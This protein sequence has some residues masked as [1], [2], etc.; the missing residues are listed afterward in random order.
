[1]SALELVVV[2]PGDRDE[3]EMLA[4]AFHAEDGHP[5]DHGGLRA[6]GEVAD[7]HPLARAWLIKEEGR[8]VGYT[9][10]TLGFGVEYG[11]ADCFLDDLYLTPEARG[12]GIGDRVMAAVEAHALG[13]GA[14]AVHLVVHPMNHRAQ[15]LYRRSGFAETD[16]ILMSKRL[17]AGPK[18]V[19]PSTENPALGEG[20]PL[21]P[22]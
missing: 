11:G 12:R 2:E 14:R 9:V 7:G 3:L 5:L 18:L 16:W 20:E 6:V 15:R 8:T 1:M 21:A 17:E 22:A 4:R 19:P 13:L 10:L